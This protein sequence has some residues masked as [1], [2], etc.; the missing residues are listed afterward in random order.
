MPAMVDG[1]DAL[2]SNNQCAG[3]PVAGE[4]FLTY[5]INKPSICLISG[6]VKFSRIC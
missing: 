5:K 3:Y 2:T 1:T 6:A 4:I